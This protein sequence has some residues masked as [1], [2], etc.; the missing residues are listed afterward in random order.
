MTPCRATP[1]CQVALSDPRSRASKPE[2]CQSHQ[3]SYT[4]LHSHDGTA[5]YIN[6]SQE[7]AYWDDKEVNED[8]ARYSRK[9]GE[10]PKIFRRRFQSG[11][12][13]IT[14]ALW[15]NVTL[16]ELDSASRGILAKGGSPKKGILVDTIANLTRS[17]KEGLPLYRVDGGA[18]F[19]W[20]ASNQDGRGTLRF[21]AVD[22]SQFYAPRVA[23]P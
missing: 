6:R 18:G 23:S 21:L 17:A 10:Q 5:V 9:I 11:G 19:V 4:I 2:G 7:P 15:G 8:I 3:V 1:V 20:I 13:D 12:P 22:P 16:E 14:I